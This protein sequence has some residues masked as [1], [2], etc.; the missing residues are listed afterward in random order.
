MTEQNDRKDSTLAEKLIAIFGSKSARELMELPPDAYL[1]APMLTTDSPRGD[2]IYKNGVTYNQERRM[3]E[4]NK[5]TDEAAMYV[6]TILRYLDASRKDRLITLNVN[7]TFSEFAGT[8][9]YETIM[10][11]KSPVTTISKAPK[12]SREP[13]ILTL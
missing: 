6:C 9:L 1:T 4:V 10:S 8:C 12:G 2:E 13:L 3:I 11:L 7:A 5:G